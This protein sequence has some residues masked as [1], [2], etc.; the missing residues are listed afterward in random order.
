M[1]TGKKSRHADVDLKPALHLADDMAFHPLFFIKCFFEIFPDLEVFRALA[2]QYDP[3]A[4]SF[5][6]VEKYVD[7]VPHFNLNVALAVGEFLDGDLALGF[8]ADIDQDM[9]RRDAD[10]PTL[11][12]SP[13]FD[14]AQALFKHRLELAGAACGRAL[15]LF[16]LLSHTY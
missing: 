3:A 9:R 12:D 14:R 1:G 8:I 6:R 11:N 2:R 4:F 10:D 13:G 5:R 15:F 16:I 7:V